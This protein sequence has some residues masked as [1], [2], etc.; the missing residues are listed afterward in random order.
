MAS[1]FIYSFTFICSVL[2]YEILDLELLGQRVPGSQAFM[3]PSEQT[4]GSPEASVLM[5]SPVR[6]PWRDHSFHVG[7]SARC[8]LSLDVNLLCI[9]LNETFAKCVLICHFG[10]HFV[11]LFIRVFLITKVVNIYWGLLT[12]HQVC[13]SILQAC[14]T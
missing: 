2:Q 13:H 8:E 11:H 14:F 5:V 3:S 4:R 12:M 7:Q 10:F 1:L 6:P 9:S